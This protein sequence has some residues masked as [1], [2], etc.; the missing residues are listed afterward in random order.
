MVINAST[1]QRER[2]AVRPHPGH[3]ADHTEIDSGVSGKRLSAPLGWDNDRN[4]T[5][6]IL[7]RDLRQSV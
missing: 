6:T 1:H 2:S 7:R 5:L 4:G 3:R